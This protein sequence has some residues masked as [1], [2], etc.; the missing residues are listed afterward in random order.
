MAILLPASSLL[1][2]LSYK[3]VPDTDSD[4]EEKVELDE[5][6]LATPAIALAQ[7]D[8]LANKM[9]TRA[10]EGFRLGIQS[11]TEYSTEN[12]DRIRALESKVDHYEDVLGTFLARLSQHQM[13]DEDGARITMLLKAIGDFE[14]ISDHSVNILESIEELR[15]K[16]IELSDSAKEELGVLSNA[17]DEILVLTEKSFVSNDLITAHKVE[18]LEEVID[19]LKR[20]LR[21]SH[22][23]RLKGGE[24][25]VEAG[26][27]WSD[28]LTDFERVGDHCS[29]I[30]L[31]VIDANNHNMNAHAALKAIPHDDLDF[32]KQYIEYSE[33]YS[34]K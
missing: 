17:V 34:I 19:N 21:N 5:R 11:L 13:S 24:C 28:M 9:A 7:S 14:R 6:L 26:F 12:A 33:K 29:N 25:T 23:V 32:K 1:E 2:K 3:L 18:P 22:V 27:V 4:K 8:E 16:K 10:I 20:A 30:A 31:G 15:E